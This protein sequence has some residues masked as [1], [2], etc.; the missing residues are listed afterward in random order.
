MD[1]PPPT[2]DADRILASLE[3]LGDRIEAARS[4]P[5]EPGTGRSGALW[6]L[7]AVLVVVLGVVAGIVGFAADDDDAELALDGGTTVTTIAAPAASVTATTEAPTTTVVPTTTAAPTTAA[8]TTAAAPR[9]Q[10]GPSSTEQAPRD[11]AREAAEEAAAGARDEAREA[12]EEAA[13]GARGE[14]TVQPGDSF[15]TIAED[16]TARRL[17]REPTVAEVTALWADILDANA[18][19]LVEPG[20]PDLI[21]PGQVMVLPGAAAAP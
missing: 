20:N 8:P 4:A 2:D 7:G 10:T 14:V 3:D 6:A 16:E 21:L 15:W 9:E 12:A 1:D 11:E 5:A 19:R 17:G 13:A 18:D